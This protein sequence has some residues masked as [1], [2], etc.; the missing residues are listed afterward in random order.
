MKYIIEHMEPKVYKW[1]LLEYTHISKIVGKKNLIFT[2]VKAGRKLLEQIGKVYKESINDLGF[3]NICILD[4]PADKTLSAKDNKFDYILLG[5]ILGDYP[6]RKRTKKIKIKAEKRDLGPKQMSTDTAAYVAKGLLSGKKLTDFKFKD[7][8]EIFLGSKESV[9][10][11][12]R[13]VEVDGKILLPKG[14][15]EF[16]K[17]KKDF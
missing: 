12:F 10:L 6:R 2:N 9:Q 1:C 14:F 4:F 11:P 8:I 17:R 13:Y 15:I 16:L 7:K 5:G 3:K